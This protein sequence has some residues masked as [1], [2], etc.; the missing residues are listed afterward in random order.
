[1]FRALTTALITLAASTVFAA[2]LRESTMTYTTQLNKLQ[3]GDVQYYL[4]L[5]PEANVTAVHVAVLGHGVRQ[6]AA[7]LRLLD[8]K[9][10]LLV[11]VAIAKLQDDSTWRFSNLGRMSAVNDVQYR[12]QND[13]EIAV[14]SYPVRESTFGLFP[15]RS[16]CRLVQS[17]HAAGSAEFQKIVGNV[18]GVMKFHGAP[19]F[20]VAQRCSEFNMMF[21][22]SMQY[23]FFIDAGSK[24][25]V[26][27]Y[28]QFF[29]RKAA[30][31]LIGALPFMNPE[32]K[33]GS[34]VLGEIVLF[35]DAAQKYLSR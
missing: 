8:L 1:M 22:Y 30:A 19:K 24:T 14:I 12:P 10:S 3:N 5:H 9:S 13:S 6:G 25:L 7:N 4:K 34:G 18:G 29:V 28:G 17:K 33:I 35:R 20:V 11:N 2:N 16:E 26:Q 15:S 31:N 32:T 21:D 23:L 27:T